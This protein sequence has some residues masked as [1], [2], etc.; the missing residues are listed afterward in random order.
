MTSSACFG[1]Q[2]PGR[3]SK[4]AD[5]VCR[6]GST[7]AQAASARALAE[8][9]IIQLLFTNPGE[10]LNRPTLGGGLIELIFG[11]SS[12]E[13]R[14]AVQFQVTSNLQQWLGTT[15]NVVSVQVTGTDGQLDVTITYQLRGDPVL[16]TTTVSP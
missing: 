14:A 16:L 9:R 10:R 4:G 3:Y 6:T 12:D 15:I 8:Q 1:P 5:S 13:M 11:A 2:L 7:T